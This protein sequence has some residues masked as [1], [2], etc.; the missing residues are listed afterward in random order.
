MGSS[1][2]S[3]SPEGG[4]SLITTEVLHT[5]VEFRQASV[6]RNDRCVSFENHVAEFDPI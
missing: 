6:R 5:I 2:Q 1:G 4:S 3:L